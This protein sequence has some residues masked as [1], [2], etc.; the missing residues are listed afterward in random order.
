MQSNFSNNPGNERVSA[1]GKTLIGYD[2]DLLND[3]QELLG[4]E[5]D[6]GLQAMDYSALTTSL[7]EN[8]LDIGAAALC[9][10][11]ERKE[12][13]DFSDIYCDSGQVVMVNKNDDKGIK[14]V[15]DL[16]DKKIA[17]EREPHLILM[18]ARTL[19]VQRLKYMTRSQ[20][21]M[22]LWSREK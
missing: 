20:L 22:N 16:K 15:D 2:V 12:V 10:T 1:D 8:K 18:Q 5:I 13:M 6:G 7:A 4:F 14:S 17:V 9:A 19:Q 3:L 11:D 21:H